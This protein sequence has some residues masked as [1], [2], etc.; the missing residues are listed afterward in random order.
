MSS[1]ELGKLMNYREMGSNCEWC[2]T[3]PV[4]W[5]GLGRQE[6]LAFSEGVREDQKGPLNC[7]LKKEQKSCQQEGCI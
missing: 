7:V 4:T 5:V 1:L 2:V 6:W 3:G